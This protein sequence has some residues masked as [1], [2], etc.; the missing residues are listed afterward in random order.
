MHIDLVVTPDRL[1][2]YKDKVLIAEQT[3]VSKTITHLGLEGVKAYLGKSVYGADPYFNGEFDNIAL[4]YRALSDGEITSATQIKNAKIDGSKVSC[5]VESAI[6]KK[7]IIIV[8]C[9]DAQ[10]CVTEAKAQEFTA[11]EGTTHFETTASESADKVK[12]MFWESQTSM[13][14]YAECA[15]VEK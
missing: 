8:A 6:E 9:Y 4:Y 1:A 13:T 14:P 5:D 12:I 2:V 7:G 11:A 3:N 15:K 10:G